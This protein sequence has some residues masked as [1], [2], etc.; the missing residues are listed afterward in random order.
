MD[1][2]CKNAGEVAQW[3]EKHPRVERVYYPGLPSHPEHQLA[4][5]QMKGFGGMVSFDLKGTPQE[6]VEVMERMEIFTLGE[7]LGGVESLCAYPPKMSHASYSAEERA[8]IGIKDTLIRLSV[9]IEDIEDI[10]Q[11]LQQAIG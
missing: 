7:S 8:K 11:D 4:A 3:L 1:Q 5:N 10:I 2:H 6:A 9:G